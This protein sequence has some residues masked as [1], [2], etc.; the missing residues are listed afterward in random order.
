MARAVKAQLRVNKLRECYTD[1]DTLVSLT[2]KM[3]S[4]YP[5]ITETTVYRIA[6]IAGVKVNTTKKYKSKYSE[7]Y[8][9][10]YAGR[11]DYVNAYDTNGKRTRVKKELVDN[12]KYFDSKKKYNAYVES[13]DAG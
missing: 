13:L 10:R 7:R 9:N 5:N 3:S 12:Q 8:G 6:K 4:W 1:G 2:E 11:Y